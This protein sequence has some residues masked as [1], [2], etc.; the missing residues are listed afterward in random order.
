MWGTC[1]SGRHKEA[2]ADISSHAVVT[3]WFR[4]VTLRRD[5]YT[6][7]QKRPI[8]RIAN[9]VGIV[10]VCGTLTLRALQSAQP[11]RDFLWVLHDRLA[12]LRSLLSPRFMLRRRARFGDAKKSSV[13]GNRASEQTKS[14]NERASKQE[15]VRSR[16]F[17]CAVLRKTHGSCPR[18]G[19]LNESEKRKARYARRKASSLTSY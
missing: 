18:I 8:C 17:G 6:L 15:F 19:D 16:K 4:F 9:A 7:A 14:E 11:L 13:K 2:A 3:L 12:V 1:R 10:C 5:N